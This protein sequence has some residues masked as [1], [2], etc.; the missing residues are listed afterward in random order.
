MAWSKAIQRIGKGTGKRAEKHRKD[1]E[2]HT[3]QCREAI[4]AWVMPL[5]RVVESIDP[6]PDENR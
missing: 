3:N 6:M 4:P 1:A 2:E 5:Y